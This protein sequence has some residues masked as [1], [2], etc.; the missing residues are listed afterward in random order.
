[1]QEIQD[2]LKNRSGVIH[3]DMARRGNLKT[4]IKNSNLA[5]KVLYDLRF[6]G[7]QVYKINPRTGGME[8]LPTFQY[9]E[10]R[11]TLALFGH[12]E[13]LT[14]IARGKRLLGN[15]LTKTEVTCIDVTVYEI[16][17]GEDG[18]EI[19]RT[20]NTDMEMSR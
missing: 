6:V 7:D 2:V 11:R 18:F 14:V 10:I 20:I 19:A 16:I 4:V 12:G 5:K 9:G 1:M 13:L 3:V 17:K 8:L 15:S